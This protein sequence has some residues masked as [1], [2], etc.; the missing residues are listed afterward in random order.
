MPYFSPISATASWRSGGVASSISAKIAIRLEICNF[1]PPPQ[2]SMEI[3][4]ELKIRPGPH[5][6]AAE[7]H[8]RSKVV[9]RGGNRGDLGIQAD[10]GCANRSRFEPARPARS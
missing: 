4:L 10:H 6:L 1:I 7:E 5:P 8:T 3:F 2:W 9:A